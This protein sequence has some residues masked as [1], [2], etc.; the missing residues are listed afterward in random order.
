MDYNYY[1]SEKLM[2]EKLSKPM[3]MK[4]PH[5]HESYEI[6]LVTGLV[7][8]ASILIDD[9]EHP[10]KDG[11]LVIIDSNVP[12]QTNYSKA[13]FKNRY[14][15]EIHPLLLKSELS[16]SINLSIPEF[17][18]MHTGVHYLSHDYL[19]KIDNILQMIYDESIFKEKFYE[20]IVLLRILEIILLINRENEEKLSRTKDDVIIEPIV[21]YILENS[22]SELSLDFIS[23][24]FFI[25]KTYLS[26]KFKAI[27]GCTVHD[28]I[29]QEKIAQAKRIIALNPDITTNQAADSLGFRSTSYFCRVFKKYTGTTFKQ[30]NKELQLKMKENR[31]ITHP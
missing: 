16:N 9:E 27:M 22:R 24:T 20:E 21:K 11:A 4:S 31:I 29:N 30:F 19:N 12:H 6:F 15:I 8:T 25:E 5:H 13:S 3:I 7:G 26:H 17:F 18:K 23:E 14:L 1:F 2:V 28:Y 10:L